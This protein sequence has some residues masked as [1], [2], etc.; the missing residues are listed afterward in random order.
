M[1]VIKSMSKVIKDMEENEKYFCDHE[2]LNVYKRA[3]DFIK[4]SNKLIK[5]INSKNSTTDQR[6]KISY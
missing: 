4:W 2:K 3:I 1:S 6:E 5:R